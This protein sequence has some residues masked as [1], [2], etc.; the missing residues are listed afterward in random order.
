MAISLAGAGW[1]IAIHYRHS[2][3]P[4]RA[5]AA[6][7]QKLGR[8]A[9][10]TQADLRQPEQVEV[11]ISS[12]ARKGIALNCLINNAAVFEKDDLHSLSPESFRLHMGTNLLAP[13]LLMQSFAA[14]YKGREGNIINITDG[15]LGWSVSPNFLSYSLS[16]QALENATTMLA[17]ALAPNIRINAIAPGPTLPGKQDKKNTFARLQKIIPLART[18]TPEEI[19]AAVRYILSAH[20]LTGQTIALSGGMH[21]PPL[22]I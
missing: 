16:K 10:L 14:Q 21:L 9:H 3:V 18:A 22:F 8:K 19:C 11:M 4:A 17:R 6:E 1:D 12:L 13:L 20:S 5:L 7:V 15:I 2:A